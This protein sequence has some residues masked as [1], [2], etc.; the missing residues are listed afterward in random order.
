MTVV[1]QQLE[2]LGLSQEEEEKDEK[3]IETKAKEENMSNE[4]EE[5]LGKSSG[6]GF[7]GWLPKVSL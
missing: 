7:S 2:H 3:K 4:K 1:T 5:D 6:F